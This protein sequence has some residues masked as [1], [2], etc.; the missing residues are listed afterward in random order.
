[1]PVGLEDDTSEGISQ[2]PSGRCQLEVEEG[3]SLKPQDEEA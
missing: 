2:C 3:L 1:M